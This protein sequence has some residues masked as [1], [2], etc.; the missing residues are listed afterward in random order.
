MDNKK[1]ALIDHVIETLSKAHI[2]V[3]HLV[4]VNSEG[5]NIKFGDWILTSII[6]SLDGSK[7]KRLG[8]VC[9]VRRRSG[10]FKEDTFLLRDLDGNLTLHYNQTFKKVPEWYKEELE[11]ISRFSPAQE[12]EQNPEHNYFVNGEEATGFL[13]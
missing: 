11:E 9:Q 5:A 2:L 10:L 6:D 8:Y 13:V 4:V 3:D 1:M 7:E 12:K